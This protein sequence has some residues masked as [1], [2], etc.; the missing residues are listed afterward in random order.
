MNTMIR[1]KKDRDSFIKRAKQVGKE[2]VTKYSSKCIDGDLNEV[3]FLS[4][5]SDI[6]PQNEKMR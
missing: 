4:S 3:V 5:F 6:G 1:A 2:K